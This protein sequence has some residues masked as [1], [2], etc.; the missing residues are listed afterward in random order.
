MDINQAHAHL[1]ALFPSIPD[2][3]A[4]D[5]SLTTDEADRVGRSVEGLIA[6]SSSSASV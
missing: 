1:H 5:R 3:D 4:D 6:L 2:D